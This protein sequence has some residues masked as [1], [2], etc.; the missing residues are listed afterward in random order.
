MKLNNDDKIL[1][2]TLI[3]LLVLVIS[4]QLYF[5][6]NFSYWNFGDR[7]LFRAE[8]LFSEFQIYGA[9]L[10]KQM[11]K[12]VPGGF[13]SY[14]L[15]VLIQFTQNINLIYLITYSLYLFSLL[16]LCYA[17]TKH[18][19]FI[20]GLFS[21]LILFT[22]TKVYWQLSMMLNPFFGFPFCLA[23]YAFFYRFILTKNIKFRKGGMH[24][25]R[26]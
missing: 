9:E 16:Y 4:L 11:G 3:S 2:I 26:V 19:N 6:G 10:D 7:D 14:Y 8:N 24:L 23:S 1:S 12:R 20:A 17:V 13:M 5:S 25:L 21:G 18:V 15:W 22:A